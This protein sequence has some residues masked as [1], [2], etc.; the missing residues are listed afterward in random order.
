MSKPTITEI[1]AQLERDPNSVH[2]ATDGQVLMTRPLNAR[3][4]QSIV[5]L[6]RNLTSERQGWRRY[7][8][9]RWL[10][11]AE[12]LRADAQ[13]IIDAMDGWESEP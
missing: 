3:T 7:V 10:I 9:G 6:L 1:E 13:R 11:A 5:T 12:S 4:R 8:F 2:L